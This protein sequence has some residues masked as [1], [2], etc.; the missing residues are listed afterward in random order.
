MPKRDR[1]VA[2]TGDAKVTLWI[3]SLPFEATKE[4]IAAHFATA[5]GYKHGSEL[6]PAVRLILKD[7]KFKGTAFVDMYSW[8]AVNRGL[9]LHDSTFKPSA[10]GASRKIKVREAV[11][12]SVVEKIQSA[13]K[14]EPKP[15]GRK[16]PAAAVEYS[17]EEGDD[18]KARDQDEAAD[19][20]AEDDAED[21]A[22][23]DSDGDVDH[24][25]E[26]DPQ[27]KRLHAEKEYLKQRRKLANMQVTC[28]TCEQAFIFTVAEQEFFLEKGWS[29][30]R[31]RCKPC[32][33]SRKSKPTRAAGGE[34]AT[35]A[36]EATG[37]RRADGGGRG[38]GGKGGGKRGGGDGK[39]GGGNGGGGKGGG[40]GRGGG[41]KGGG[42]KGGGGKGGGG[43][44]SGGGKGGG[45]KGGGPDMPLSFTFGVCHSC[46]EEGHK[47]ADCPKPQLS[48]K[49]RK[50]RKRA[51]TSEA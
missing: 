46:G 48:W 47:R 1:E 18:E 32:S 9:A 14:S 22:E 8:E 30:P 12:K 51:K 7:G 25:G 35:G 16:P 23:E 24:N 6:L 2:S 20:D 29:I 49:E 27:R 10:K 45:G 33:T 17:D 5:A 37:S 21:D 4:D 50:E 34:E 26:V 43:G 3:S 13:F 11:Q 15:I 36:Q 39:G 19:E 40:G 42:G 31:P 38:D 44:R 28:N 41:G